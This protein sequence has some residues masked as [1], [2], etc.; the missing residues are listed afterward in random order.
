MQKI[1]P[2]CSQAFEADKATRTYCSH[3]C[4]AVSKRG[5]PPANKTDIQRIC[6]VCGIT[7]RAVPSAIKSRGA[8]Y[9]SAGCFHKAHAQAMLGRFRKRV[10]K[11]CQWCGKTYE[12]IPSWADASH[13]C[14]RA[15][16]YAFKRTVRGDTHPLK[17]EYVALVCEWCGESFTVKPSIAAKDRTRFCSRRCVGAWTVATG[18]PSP[19]SIEIAVAAIL[20][21]LSLSYVAQAPMGPFLCDFALKAHRLV[22]ECDGTFWHASERQQAKDARKDSWLTNHGYTVLRLPESRIVNDPAWCQAQIIALYP[23]DDRA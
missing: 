2:V 12:I 17:K 22:I 6:S 3:A 15:C 5:K 13:Y 23:S 8:K 7:F 4:Y 20:D 10:S 18:Q 16:H 19:T 14:S 9:C 11:V 1:C 21:G